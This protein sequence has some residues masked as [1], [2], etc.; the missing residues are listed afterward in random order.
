MASPPRAY[1]REAG[2]EA[3]FAE[4]LAEYEAT[5]RDHAACRYL[6]TIG[7]ADVAAELAPLVQVHDEQSGALSGRALA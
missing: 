1:P 6:E 5:A 7:S 3:A 4:W 2:E